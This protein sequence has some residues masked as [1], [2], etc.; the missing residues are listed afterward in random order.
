MVL[1]RRKS[2]EP[3]ALYVGT[4]Q[5]KGL[6]KFIAV[7]P[8]QSRRRPGRDPGRLRRRLAPSAARHADRRRRR[9]RRVGLRQEGDQERRRRPPA[10]RP[11]RQGGQLPGRRVPDRVTPAAPPAGSPAV[12]ARVLVRGGAAARAVPRPISPRASRSGP[13]PRSPPRWSATSPCWGRRSWTG[14]PPTRSM[15]R[16]GPARRVGALGPALRDGGAANTTA[17]PVDP[18]SCVPA[19]SGRGQPPRRPRREAVRRGGRSRPT[20]RPK[21]G[22]APGARGGGRAAGLRVRGGAGLGGPPPPAGPPIWLLIRRSLEA[23][24]R[25]QV[26]RQQRRCGDV[27]G[28]VG[29]GGLQSSPGGGILRGRQELPG[30]GAVRDAVVGRLAPP[31]DAGRVGASVR[32]PDA[33]GLEKKIPELTLDR[34]V[35]L[36]EAALREPILR[37]PRAIALVA[38]HIR[39]NKVAKA[40]H[41]KTW[42]EKH[43]GVI[44]LRL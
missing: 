1:S 41:D 42:K 9:P 11:T 27:A 38:Y 25:G 14:S 17:G 2:I 20:C 3:I 32:D 37:L 23:D 34:T 33:A 39:R 5:V 19:Y 44:F 6:Q 10:Q 18:A 29:V 7:A 28:G 24:A 13:S 35:R 40:S 22:S 43:R 21:P 30:D 15:A 8:W 31:Y 16:T 12:P 36:L 4:G 26:L